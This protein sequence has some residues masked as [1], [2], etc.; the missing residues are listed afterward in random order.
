MSKVV[1]RVLTKEGGQEIDFKME[2]DHDWSPDTRLQ[3]C[4]GFLVADI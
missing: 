4:V 1:S 3:D 2:E